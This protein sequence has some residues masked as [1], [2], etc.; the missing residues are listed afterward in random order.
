MKLETL[1]PT[2]A[3][4]LAGVVALTLALSAAPPRSRRPPIETEL[5]M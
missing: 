1:T 2:F 4:P 3:L 5:S